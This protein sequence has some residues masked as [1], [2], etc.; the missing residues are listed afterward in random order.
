MSGLRR[1]IP[2]LAIDWAIDTPERLWRAVDGTLCFADISGFTALGER[3]AQRGRV[4][5]EELVATLS[6][7]FGAMLENARARDGMLLK[8]GG[9]SLLFLFRDEDHA[10]RA[11][12]TAVEM[13]RALRKAVEIPTSVGRLQLSMSVGLHT[14]TFHFFLV[15]SSH[16]ELVL[17]GRDATRVG[18]TEAAA[19]AGEIAVSPA[20]AAALPASGVRSREDGT[21]LLRWRRPPAAAAGPRPDREVE[22]EMLQRLFP[23]LLGQVLEPGPPDPEHRVGCI[24]FIRFS[25]TDALL[26]EEGPDVVA[27]ALQRTIGTAQDALAEEGVTLL[28]VDIDSDGG[29]LF[30]GSGV[31]RASEDDEGRMLRAL[32]RIAA[33]DLPLPLQFGV[34]RGHVFAAEVGTEHR[35]AYSAMGDTTNTAARICAKAKPGAIYAHPS[36]LDHSRTLFDTQ[37]AGPFTFKGKTAPQ[38]VYA[39]GS[40]LGMRVEEAGGELPLVARDEE[41]A[42]LARA[43]EQMTAGAG[44]VVTILGAM[45]LGKTRLLREATAGLDPTLLIWLRAEPYGVSSAYRVFRDPIRSLLGVER[46]GMA[47]MREALEKGAARV[48]SGLLPWLALLG[49]VAHVDVELSPEVRALAPRF[50]PDRV[51]DTVIQLLAAIHPGSLILVFDDSQWADEASAQLLGRIARECDERPWLLLVARREGEEGFTPRDGQTLA[52]EPL[53]SSASEALVNSATEAAPLRRHEVELVIERAGGVPLFVEEIVKAV[54]QVGSVEGVPDSLEAAM[55]A[56]VDRLDPEARRVLRYASVLGNSFRTSLLAELL[57]ADEHALDPGVVVRTGNFLEADGEGRL[58]FRRALIRD[59]A[60]EGLS[61]RLR[62]RLHRVA[63]E[64]IERTV[65]DLAA[66]ADTLALHFWLAR[67]AE[68]TWRYAREAADRAVRAFAMP[69]AARLFRIALDAARRIPEVTDLNRVEVWTVLGRVCEQAGMFEAA[70]DAYRHGSRLAR[71]DPL[72]H[73][74]LLR[75]R[76]NVRERKGAFASAMSELTRATRLIEELDTPAASKLHAQIASLAATVR[77]GQERLREA[78]RLALRARALARRANE[79]IALAQALEVENEARVLLGEGAESDGLREALAIAEE[80]GSLGRASVIRMNLGV[81]AFFAGRWDEALSWYSSSRDIDVRTGDVVDAAFVETNIA[82]LLVKRGQLAEAEPLLQGAI[83]CLRA[84][85]FN[86]GTAS[87][88]LQLARLWVER[89]ALQEAESLLERVAEVFSSLGQASMGLECALVRAESQLRAGRPDAALEG[90]GRAAEGAGEDAVLLVPQ[91]AYA[92]ARALGAL[93]RHRD[94]EQELKA[95]LTSA[96]KQG[97]PY[98]EGMLLLARAEIARMQGQPPDPG[99][100]EAATAILAGLGVPR[101]PSWDA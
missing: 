31:P 24:A 70:L 89:G 44:G 46:S 78:L 67:D 85:E 28:S 84:T 13:R 33:V 11:A 57:H 17:V 82:E 87:A 64:V 56:Q 83:R 35:A 27:A 101:D 21:L 68:R 12:S 94:A 4:G 95:G 3:L 40:E 51:A 50:R 81:I 15:G 23:G 42:T 5:G 37:P 71:G 26:E 98:E 96:R 8:F 1:H 14:G 69:E 77:L 88:E 32:R 58:R 86:E 91:V 93:G 63:G 48:D 59:T 6:R 45:G 60:Y 9:D 99:D 41:L 72:A 97:L 74:E 53:S 10:V 79:R 38:V 7:V 39:V 2:A 76:A 66:N 29:K 55:A 22:P 36:V 52:L 43:V 75:K 62:R 54:R 30:L 16:R 90:V 61:Y 19:N 65:D 73:A 80:V 18:E 49:D 47:E 25:G 100:L 20:T 34:N 92:Q